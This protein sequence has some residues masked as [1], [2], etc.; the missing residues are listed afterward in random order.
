MTE[1]IDIKN[2]YVVV[3]IET[4]GLAPILK[5][6]ETC[7]IIEIGAVKITNGKIN[8]KFSTFMI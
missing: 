5:S 2:S 7:N 6:G 4:T 8:R 1:K 3:D